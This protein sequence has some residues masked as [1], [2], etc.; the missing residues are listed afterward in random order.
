MARRFTGHYV[1]FH[2]WSLGPMTLSEKKPVRL[3]PSGCIFSTDGTPNSSFRFISTQ[4]HTHRLY[5]LYNLTK[6]PL[7]DHGRTE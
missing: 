2:R 1:R 5:Y 3:D 7:V 6:V 4:K